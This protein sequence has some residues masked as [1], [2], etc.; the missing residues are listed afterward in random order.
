MSTVTTSSHWMWQTMLHKHKST[1]FLSLFEGAFCPDD[2]FG[3]IQ[4]FASKAA[5]LWFGVSEG[6][7]RVV[8][9]VHLTC[10][11]GLSGRY[12]DC[13]FFSS[14][15]F[16]YPSRRKGVRSACLFV[17]FVLPEV[18]VLLTVSCL[19]I[20]YWQLFVYFHQPVYLYC[21]L[22][23]CFLL[24]AVSVFFTDSSLSTL[25]CQL[26]LYFQCQSILY[27]VLL[28]S[29]VLWTANC[30]FTL[31]YQ[32]PVYF[33]LPALSC[34]VMTDAWTNRQ[35]VSNPMLKHW[36]VYTTQPWTQDFGNILSQIP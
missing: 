4:W 33:V 25:Y 21:Q 7:D 14:D 15:V 6:R 17:Y 3:E 1:E 35:T 34:S 24:S 22:S 27:F 28:S 26:S 8:H 32:L 29:C 30:L 10:D 16:I 19:C 20:L 36:P 12:Q 5:S 23:V 11:F 9:K 31:Y 13:S 18:G 2:A